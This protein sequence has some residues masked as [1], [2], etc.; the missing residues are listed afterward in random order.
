[1]KTNVFPFAP[2]V[3]ARMLLCI[4]KKGGCKQKR[5]PNRF[6]SRALSGIL[7]FQS[8]VRNTG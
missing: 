6:G 8:N 1:M 7:L 3:F 2:N 4:T 5:I